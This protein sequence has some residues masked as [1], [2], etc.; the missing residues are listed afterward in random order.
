MNTLGESREKL[1]TKDFV[2][3]TVCNMLLF[4]TI[5]MQTP[6]FPA[7]V[8]QAY[9]ANDFVVSLVISLFSLAAVVARALTGE[10]LRTKNSKVI[11][12]LALCTVG[13]FSAG[14]Y[15]AGHIALFLFL[16]VLVGIG[17]GMG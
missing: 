17:F 8:K 16:R 4:L 1:W 3:L 5:Q 2:L 13:I 14:Y 11:A 7:Y 12:M 10:A 15:W 9:Q 6:T